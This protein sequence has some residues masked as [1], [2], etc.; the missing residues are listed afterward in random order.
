MDHRSSVRVIPP[1]P[2]Q[3]SPAPLNRLFRRAFSS[4]QSSDTVRHTVE[5]ERWRA[6]DPA[7]SRKAPDH[8]LSYSP[9]PI[10]I[11]ADPDEFYRQP[12]GPEVRPIAARRLPRRRMAPSRRDRP[13]SEIFKN[14]R[15]ADVDSNSCTQRPTLSGTYAGTELIAS[16]VRQRRSPSAAH[17][18][19]RRRSISCTAP[20]LIADGGIQTR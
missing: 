14:R 19:S 9:L 7:R 3:S 18:S 16:S 2:T 13:S 4:S 11:C 15:N 20:R 6:I 12:Y 10:R 8:E 1:T 5:T 17:G